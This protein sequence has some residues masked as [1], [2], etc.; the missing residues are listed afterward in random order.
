MIV[1]G[2]RAIGIYLGAREIDTSDRQEFLSCLE[3]VA[4]LLHSTRTTAVNLF[5]A[6]GR[7]M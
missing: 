7:M 2:A 1:R 3:K 6:I 5:W 4:Q